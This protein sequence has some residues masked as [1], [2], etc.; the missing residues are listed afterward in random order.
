MALKRHATKVSASLPDEPA[1]DVV[2]A[3]PAPTKFARLIA[4][5]KTLKGT[6]VAIAGV[7][8]VLGGLA[9]YWN[10]YQAARSGTQSSSLLALVGTGNAGPL[11]IVVLPFA[12]LTGDPQQAYV[13]DGLTVAVTAD[14]S[15]IRDAFIVST[16][17][18]LA[19][20]DKP[21]TVQQIG[22][23]LGVRFVLQGGVQRSA[24]KIRINAQLA[25]ATSNAQLWSETFDG[26]QA[27]LFA[28]QDLVT[29]RIGNSIGREMVIVAARDSETRKSDPKV[30]DLMVRARA[31]VLKPVSLKNY[32]E[33]QALYRQVLLLE[34]SNVQAMVGLAGAL[35]FAVDNGFIAD[36]VVS[37]TR[38]VEGRDLALKA[39]ELDS[40]IASIY[41]VLGVYAYRH[42]NFEG[43]RRDFAT[44][45]SLEPKDPMRYN[46]V[47][48]GYLRAGD[49]VRAIGLLSQG[50]R[51]DPKNLR[52]IFLDNM[53]RA[54]FMIGDDEAA[55]EWLLKAVDAN[56]AYAP[57]HAYLAMAYA[58]QGDHARARAAAVA[59][60]RA[61]PKYSLSRSEAPWPEQPV[62]FR[63]WWETKLL[64]AGRLA[65]LP[66]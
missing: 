66:E 17:T 43:A 18:A 60:L 52:E 32:E 54:Q 49:P 59:L 44:A 51:L 48:W 36:P 5:L 30:A 37:E 25:D 19:Y 26:S 8:A 53:G 14:L 6:I 63:E 39:R 45:L 10:A 31:L 3:A 42:G 56:P 47:A 16:A 24:D 7:G 38:L 4:R 23:E 58:R 64:P 22:K 27:D 20:K 1:R 15:R 35:A 13:A 11:S 65:G 21:V 41:S 9:G 34:P 50:I 61:D 12:N 40:S 33:R 29:T 46:A 28:L 57:P 55:I 2:T 62:A